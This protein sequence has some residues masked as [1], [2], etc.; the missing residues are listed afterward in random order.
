[1]QDELMVI[2][3]LNRLDQDND[4][5]QASITGM[6]DAVKASTAEVVAAKAHLAASQA[7]LAARQE[8]ERALNRKLNDYTK[9]RDDTRTLIDTGRAPDYQTAQRQL[10]QLA[11]ITD[12]LETETLEAIMAREEAESELA[13]AEQRLTDGRAADT[14]AREQYHASSPGLKAQIAERLERRPGLLDR[15]MI[16]R[17]RHYENLRGREMYAIT[18]IKA[19]ACED[20][21]QR[22]PSQAVNEVLAQSR[23]HTCRNCGRFFF[24]VRRARPAEE[25]EEAPGA[26]SD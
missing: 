15:L 18:F 5:D 20:C 17:R 12:D 7:E 8:A 9:R 26:G 10:D 16:D 6:I 23:I 3:D 1:M 14:A 24:D 25:G 2:R 21:H 11:Q 4:A 13:S 22:A 19:G